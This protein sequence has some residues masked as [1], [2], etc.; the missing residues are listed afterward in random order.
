VALMAKL[1]ELLL[2]MVDERGSD[3]HLMVGA[4]PRVR[5]FGELISMELPPLTTESMA[6]MLHEICAADNWERYLAS[7][8][9]DFAYELPRVARFRANYLNNHLG[10]AAVFRQIPADILSF[11][12][13]GLPEA[14]KGLCS[15]RS[16]LVF[17]TGPTG[18]GKSTTMAAVIDHINQTQERY[19]LTVEDP[20]EFVHKSKRSVILH[21]E[22]GSH[23]H[24][25][26]EALKGA[27]HAD[28][29]VLFIGELREL[30]TIK[31][32]LTCASMGMLVYGTLHTNNAPKTIDRVIDAFP[33]DQQ[34]QIRAML[35]E[36][37]R[38]VIS[39]LLCR[40]VDE[41]RIAV[42][43]I[44][45]PHAALKNCIRTG[46]IASIRNII[47]SGAAQGMCTM[48]SVLRRLLDDGVISP[49]EADLKATNKADFALA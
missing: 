30:E 4:P 10:M 35:A 22:I 45:L 33:A 39:Q 20:V 1:D 44:L 38:G 29:D 49:A 41:G 15:L 2:M 31:L 37:L 7:G 42:H 14:L 46:A 40:R 8:D 26:A 32:A 34:N 18:S 24:S 9:L 27:I 11:D 25:F 13:L 47:E 23:A 12:Q 36:C 19:I 17:V 21:R 28:A 43:E 6:T 16:G 3:L 5:I 48:D